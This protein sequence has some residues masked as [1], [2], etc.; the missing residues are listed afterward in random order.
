MITD[1][2]LDVKP[3]MISLSIQVILSINSSHYP[4]CISGE[5][6]KELFIIQ[7]PWS[8]RDTN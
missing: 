8:D 6:N 4:A 3:A 5:P 7:S 2:E 1:V